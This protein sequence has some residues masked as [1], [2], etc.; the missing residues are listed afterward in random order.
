MVDLLVRVQSL[1]VAGIRLSLN[2][3]EQVHALAL[4]EGVS[5]LNLVGAPLTLVEVVH[6]QLAHERVK[7]AML[8]IG[9][10]GLTGEASSVENLET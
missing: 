6:V 4:E 5:E 8:E 7:V 1:N 10:K 2:L 9:R 3:A